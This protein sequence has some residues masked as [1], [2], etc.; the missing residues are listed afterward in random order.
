MS[1]E[2]TIQR[3]ILLGGMPAAINLSPTEHAVGMS[4]S[5]LFPTTYGTPTGLMMTMVGM[6]TDEANLVSAFVTSVRMLL[7]A[8]EAEEIVEDEIGTVTQAL[9]RLDAI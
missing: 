4:S 5:N 7:D 3:R 9:A 8:L 1:F 2:E 6:T